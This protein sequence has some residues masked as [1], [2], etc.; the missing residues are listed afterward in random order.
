MTEK[1]TAITISLR[2]E[3]GFS[4]ET[5]CGPIMSEIMSKDEALGCIASWLYA[6]LDH[7]TRPQFLRTPE[8][9][10]EQ[11]ERFKKLREGMGKES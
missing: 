11:E 8:E 3:G 7:G 2:P 10:K 9:R 4:L 6:H 5:A 1:I